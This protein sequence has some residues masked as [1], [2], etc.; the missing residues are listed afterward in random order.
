MSSGVELRRSVSI[1]ASRASSN[2]LGETSRGRWRARARWLRSSGGKL[3]VVHVDADAGDGLAVDELHQ[4]AGDLLVIEHDV[5]GP[6]EVAGS[7]DA[8]WLG[9]GEAE[10]EREQRARARGTMEQ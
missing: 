10:R 8:R 2:V 1:A 9:G 3:G 4:D 7:V 5:V 6:A